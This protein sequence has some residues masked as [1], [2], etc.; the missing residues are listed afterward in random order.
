MRKLKD[1]KRIALRTDKT[2]TSFEATI[3][4]CG[5]DAMLHAVAHIAAERQLPCQVSLEGYMA[6]GVGACLGC[7]A[8]GKTHSP[9]TPDFRCV[10]TEG[11]VFESSELKW[12]K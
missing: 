3:Y 1:F 2:D 8:E 12:E 4:A 7:V 5:P 9:A 10:C 11:P 6:C